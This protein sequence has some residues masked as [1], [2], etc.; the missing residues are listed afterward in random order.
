[1]EKY[2]TGFFLICDSQSGVLH[3]ADMG[4]SHGA[5]IRNGVVHQLEKARVNLPVGVEPNIRPQVY[6]LAIRPGDALII[7]TDG[8]TE[9]DNA[10]GEE[11][12]DRRLLDLAL[13]CLS[14]GKELGDLLPPAM[15]SFRKNTPRLDDMSYLFFRF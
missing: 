6:R 9:Q 3:L 14:T 1:M 4:H 8:I 10:E 5:L 11:F 13:E 15:E 12:G 2:L 7:Y